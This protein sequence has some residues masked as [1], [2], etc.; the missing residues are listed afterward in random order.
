[1]I[2]RLRI[3]TAL[4]ILATASSSPATAQQIPL[5]TFVAGQPARV[6]D[7]NRNF[8]NLK[9]AIELEQRRNAA[10]VERIRSLEASLSK[11]I[12]LNQV[13]SIEAV[14]GVRTVRFSGVNLQVV[15]GTN[16]TESINGAGNVIIG[17]DE[18]NLT[19][20][21]E[22]CSRATSS[23]GFP[24]ETEAACLAAGGVFAATHKSGSHNLVMGTNNNY[25][26]AAG[27]VAGRL[28]SVNEMYASVL[29]G[30][31]NRS[32]GTTA[33][34][35]GGQGNLTLSRNHGGTGRTGQSRDRTAVDGCRRTLEHRQWQCR[36][37]QR[38]RAQ[39]GIGWHRVGQRR[40]RQYRIGCL[41]ECRRR[42]W[43][44]GRRDRQQR[45]GRQHHHGHRRGHRA[46]AQ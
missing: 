14:N 2:S 37:G 28:N 33:V 17:Y 26:S 31:Q 41:L 38:W 11:M 8:T 40:Q 46:L 25:S 13:V 21:Q 5:T 12:A 39:H 27:I 19:A 1:M 7:V 29:G 23:T 30:V 43:Q 15:N 16:F 10:L 6:S 44:Y 18:T 20:T 36:D 35:V 34:I 45:P 32:S 22:F 9:S 42:S 4:A 3:A 24:T